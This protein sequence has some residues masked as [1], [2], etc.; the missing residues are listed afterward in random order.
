MPSDCPSTGFV[1]WMSSIEVSVVSSY[2][3]GLARLTSGY[4]TEWYAELFQA[5]EQGASSL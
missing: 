4:N 2:A 3:D 1:A 5:D